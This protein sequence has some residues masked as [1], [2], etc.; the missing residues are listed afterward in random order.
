MLGLLIGTHSAIAAPVYPP[1]EVITGVTFDM[2]SLRNETPGNRK[3]A[4]D[5]DNWTITW[6]DDGH[7]YTSFGDGVGFSTSNSTRASLGVAR[8]EGGK[9]NYAA[10][11]VFKTG[12]DSGG[13]GGKSLG[14]ISIDGVLWM[15]RNGNGS[16]SG[17]LR[18]TILYRSTNHGSSWSSTGVRWDDNDFSGGKGFFAPTFL[19][20]G[21]DYD[22]AR[23][24]FVYIY[25]PEVT[26]SVSSDDWNV[27]KPGIISLLRV[28]KESLSSQSAYQYFAGLDGNGNPTWSNDRNQRAPVFEDDVNGVMRISV[29]YNA[30]LARYILVTQQVSRFENRDYHIGIYE[31]PEPWGPWRTVLFKN[32]GDVGP[33]LNNGHKTVYWNFSNK[34]LSS[35]GRNFVMVYTGNGA[36]EWG[37]VEGTWSTDSGGADL[38]VPSAPTDLTV[39]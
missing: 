24:N 28:N 30:G 6:A 9:D 2:S 1:S 10:Y 26:K 3:A 16:E 17:A 15:F 5:S 27:Q 8:I 20:F 13:W 31:A 22:G 12:E 38:I 35:D 18:Q 4:N 21:R 11:D 19:Q 14:I 34:W 32:P 25:A 23:D 7:Q 29:S 36:D 33:G 37:T 39:E